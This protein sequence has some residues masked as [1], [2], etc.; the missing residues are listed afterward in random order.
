MS[1]SRGTAALL[2]VA[3]LALTVA[4]GCGPSCQRIADA[5]AAFRQRPVAPRLHGELLVPLALGNRLLAK[6]LDG[7]GPRTITL[8]G[9]G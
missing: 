7:V 3:T 4:S 1:A 8:P 2:C 5:R 9:L 6:T